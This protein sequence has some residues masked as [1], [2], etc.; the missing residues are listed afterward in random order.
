MNRHLLY[1]KVIKTALLVSTIFLADIIH[2]DEYNSEKI[3]NDVVNKYVTD[4][5]MEPSL[6]AVLDRDMWK[7]GSLEKRRQMA[8]KLF[9]YEECINLDIDSNATSRYSYFNVF[10]TA[11]EGSAAKD[12]ADNNPQ[13]SLKKYLADQRTGLELYFKW[14]DQEAMIKTIED[15]EDNLPAGL[16]THYSD[17]TLKAARTY[18][19]YALTLTPVFQ[20]EKVNG[21]KVACDAVLKKLVKDDF[22]NGGLDYR[23]Y[24]TDG[25]SGRGI[26][27]DDLAA[28]IL[29]Q[30]ID[31][32]IKNKDI[33]KAIKLWLS[34]VE[35]SIVSLINPL[36]TTQRYIDFI[37]Q[38][39]LDEKIY[40]EKLIHSINSVEI[41]QTDQESVAAKKAALSAI[42]KKLLWRS[43][44]PR[45]S[46]NTERL[47]CYLHHQCVITQAIQITGQATLLGNSAVK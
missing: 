19:D 24:L 44:I 20:K 11:V 3:I 1:V 14:A 45:F 28:R 47:D 16:L 7:D 37:H 35:F 41:D 34:L 12:I 46:K 42:D 38:F 21:L 6:P 22:S 26:L 31:E 18:S 8:R 39:S 40:F 43:N 33:D 15:I 17:R 25:G 10:D 23:I 2:A 5:V 4:A 9:P 36:E 13:F 29:N 32:A 30:Q 27:L